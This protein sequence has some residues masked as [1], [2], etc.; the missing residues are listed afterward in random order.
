MCSREEQKTLSLWSNCDCSYGNADNVQINSFLH[1]QSKIKYVQVTNGAHIKVIAQQRHRFTWVDFSILEFS[2]NCSTTVT[3]T[4]VINKSS[5]YKCVSRLGCWF[6]V[7]LV[8]VLT[9][10]IM[11]GAY[12]HSQIILEQHRQS[13]P[14]C[15]NRFLKKLL[16]L[17]LWQWF[18]SLRRPNSQKHKMLQ[19]SCFF[20]RWLS[21]VL[22]TTDS[23]PLLRSLRVPKSLW[24]R[25]V[26]WQ[27]WQSSIHLNKQWTAPCC[28][29]PDTEPIF[30]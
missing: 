4:A 23:W 18:L 12:L 22:Q 2:L 5:W 15:Q 1:L 7:L 17:H 28:F 10:S 30:E 25:S 6:I 3:Q 14:T 29:S 26:T 24:M 8:I 9:S 20:S 27:V 11:N 21:L 16:S 13:T 19:K